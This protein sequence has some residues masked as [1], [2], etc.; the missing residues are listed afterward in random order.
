MSEYWRIYGGWSALIRS[1]Y[2]HVA[3]VVSLLLYPLW[4]THLWW[5]DVLQVVPSLLGFSLGGYAM[6]LAVGS[7]D[8][9]RFISGDNDDGGSSPVI[10]INATFV[11]F[12]F[13]QLLSLLIAFVGK[14]YYFELAADSLVRKIL[15][16]AL[17]WVCLVG[18]YLG[19]TLFIYA[20]FTAWAATLAIFRASRWY[21]QFVTANR[22]TAKE[23]GCKCKCGD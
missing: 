1:R 4:S 8:F 21:D 23:G 2:F 13:V 3:I 19:F 5:Q 12:I 18:S 9:R 6:W 15:G 7:E 10:S 22:D 20:L 16:P 11:H 17:E 14:A